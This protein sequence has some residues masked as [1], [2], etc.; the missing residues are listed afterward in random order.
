MIFLILIALVLVAATVRLLVHAALLPRLKL[1]AHLREIDA[2]GFEAMGPVGGG[3]GRRSP[4]ELLA[5]VAERTGSFVM[6]HLP[7][8]PALKRRDLTAAALYDV[9]PETVHGYRTMAALLFPATV[10]FCAAN[11]GGASGL[12]FV[13]AIAV[14]VG[15]WFLPAAGIQVRGQRRLNEIDRDLPDLIDLLTATMEAG[16]GFAASLDL[17]AG[18]FKGALGEELRITQ[19][20]QKLGVSNDQA[21]KDMVERCD[22]GSMRSFV[23]TLRTAESL[24]VS[25]GASMRELAHDVR[26]RRRQMA[27]ERMRKAAVKLLF[28]LIFLIFPALLI[29]VMYPAVYTLIHQLSG[30]VH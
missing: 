26:R 8:L 6:R 9:S 17:V 22:T 15:G 2:Y 25:I 16:M 12:T 1:A 7:A 30:T 19:Q 24:G 28:P 23:R 4:A 5:A 18:R 11:T 27:E 21:L 29:E 3:A 10:L 14:G 20:Q 13:I